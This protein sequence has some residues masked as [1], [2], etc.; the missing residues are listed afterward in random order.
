[1]KIENLIMWTFMVI[2]FMFVMWAAGSSMQFQ[3]NCE[4]VCGSKDILTPVMQ[5]QEVCMCN[6]GNGKWR[7]ADARKD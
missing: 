2:V 6:E 5:G 3:R 4:E 7:F 1:M